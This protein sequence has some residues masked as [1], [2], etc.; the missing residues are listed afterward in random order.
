[1]KLKKN[2]SLYFQRAT[3]ELVDSK[4]DL[5]FSRTRKVDDSGGY[6]DPINKELKVATW[7][8][9]WFTIFVHE[10]N[11]YKQWRGETKLWCAVDYVDFFDKFPKRYLLSTQLM[12]QECDRMVL[13][14]INKWG[15]EGMTN[16]V[17]EANSYHISYVNIANNKKW[18]QKAPYR[19]PE[20]VKL[21]PNDR[22]FNV[23]ELSKPNHEL[24]SLI[25]EKCF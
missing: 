25:D 12:E 13:N 19:F 6:F 17:A 3:K 14:D 4:I 20:I 10:Y 24:Y 8:K 23:A 15:L 9:D 7:N 18:V 22:F 5:H 16:H 1:M 11:H 21:C 2:Q